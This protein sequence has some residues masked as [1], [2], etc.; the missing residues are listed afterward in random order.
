MVMRKQS[1]QKAL[2]RAYTDL[3]EGLPP[4][5]VSRVKLRAQP[6]K[7]IALGRITDVVY[8]K[9][10]PEGKPLYHHDFASHARP[11]LARDEHGK[12]HV[13]G[14]RYTVNERGIVDAMKHRKHRKHGRRHAKHMSGHAFLA[15]PTG[16]KSSKSSKSG[17]SGR[18]NTK[19][20]IKGLLI[21]GV[22]GGIY[23]FLGDVSLNQT[24]LSPPARGALQGLVGMALG[25]ALHG[26][27]PNIARGLAIVGVADVISGGV[28]DYRFQALVRSM[29]GGDAG[30]NAGTASTPTTNAGSGLSFAPGLP[31]AGAALPTGYGMR[32][33]ASC[34][35]NRYAR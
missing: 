16:S 7:L 9:A 11:L 4:D 14:G 33:Q 23:E 31:P 28:Q 19:E 15:N 17:S 8:E 30:A 25:L 3:H 5:R 6:K 26:I 2:E 1:E 18:S 22:S 24:T 29:T 20:F 10:T 32:T 35:V 13:L 34:G 27:A 21:S 12:L